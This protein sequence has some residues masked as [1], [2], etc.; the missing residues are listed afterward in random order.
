MRRVQFDA[1]PA[2]LVR[3]PR[4]GDKL[5]HDAVEVPVR[6]RARGPP[7]DAAEPAREGVRPDDERDGGRREGRFGSGSAAEPAH[8]LTARVVQL[9][10][11]ERR[12]GG[13]GVGS[14]SGSSR[15]S[16]FARPGPAG[17][18]FPDGSS[19]SDVVRIRDSDV[20]RQSEVVRRDLDVPCSNMNSFSLQPR[21]RSL[22]RAQTR[23]ERREVLTGDDHPVASSRPRL[24]QRLFEFPEPEQFLHRSL[25]SQLQE[26]DCSTSA[27]R[28]VLTRETSVG[29]C[30]W[31]DQ[32]ELT[33][34]SRFGSTRPHGSRTLLLMVR[35]S[36]RDMLE[37]T[38][39]SADSESSRVPKVDRVMQSRSDLFPAELRKRAEKRAGLCRL[40]LHAMPGFTG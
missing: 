29:G 1:V 33:L 31:E 17:E 36:S 26:Q 40:V 32:E 6:H 39:S 4:A 19:A 16:N 10:D 2:R 5:V 14:G 27:W 12:R 9:H 23:R 20:E 8:R 22:G 35:I 15:R 3:E 11:G 34:T 30:S 25:S 7:H 28:M 24:V 18:P 21:D 37:S 13:G 38:L